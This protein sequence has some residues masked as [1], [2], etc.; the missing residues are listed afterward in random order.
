[1]GTPD[2][3]EVPEAAA[4]APLPLPPEIEADEE[5]RARE[6]MERMIETRRV[7]RSSMIANLGGTGRGLSSPAN[8]ARKRLLGE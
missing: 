8:I 6:Y 3:A 5:R 2:I 4:A 1:M 7:G